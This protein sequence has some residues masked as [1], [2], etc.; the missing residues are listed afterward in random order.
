MLDSVNE[1]DLVMIPGGKLGIVVGIYGLGY[2][3][4]LINRS[5]KSPKV[6]PFRAL[7]LK[8]ICQETVIAED[9]ICI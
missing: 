7:D 6:V 3:E 1:G 9:K 2:C 5:T 8:K 4:V